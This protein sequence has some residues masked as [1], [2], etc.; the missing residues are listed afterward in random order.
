MIHSSLMEVRRRRLTMKATPSAMSS[1]AR[2]SVV[3]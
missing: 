1:G 2:T 3:S